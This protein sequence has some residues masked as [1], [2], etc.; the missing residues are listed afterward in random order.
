MPGPS[1]ASGVGFLLKGEVAWAGAE[2]GKGEHHREWQYSSLQERSPDL[3]KSLRRKSLRA[4]LCPRRPE[5]AL[6]FGLP[7][8]PTLQLALAPFS[9][10]LSH[11]LACSVLA[12]CSAVSVVSDPAASWIWTGWGPP[13][14]A[15]CWPAATDWLRTPEPSPQLSR[16]DDGVPWKSPTRPE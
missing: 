10:D 6:P 15:S 14:P 7:P 12:P 13:L 16:P 2:L 11:L 9:V 5:D 8:G 3:L 1:A 4:A